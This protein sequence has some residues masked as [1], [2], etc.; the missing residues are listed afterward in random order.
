MSE[1]VVKSIEKKVKEHNEKVKE[2]GLAEWRKINVGQAKAVVRRGL[3]AYSTSHRPSVT[4]RTQWGLARLNAFI[5]LMLKDKPKNPKYVTDNDLLPKKHPR[6]SAEKKSLDIFETVVKML[7]MTEPD[8]DVYEKTLDI[9]DY[10]EVEADKLITFNKISYKLNAEPNTVEYD[11]L[12]HTI[13]NLRLEFSNNPDEI[14][15]EKIMKTMNVLPEDGEYIQ[16]V[17]ARTGASATNLRSQ[18]QLIDQAVERW[19]TNAR[20]QEYLKNRSNPTQSVYYNIKIPKSRE[21]DKGKEVSSREAVS[22]ERQGGAARRGTKRKIR[23]SLANLNNNRFVKN[24]LKNINEI[25]EEENEKVKNEKDKKP[26]LKNWM[27][28][29]RNSSLYASLLKQGKITKRQDRLLKKAQNEVK[30]SRAGKQAVRSV[31][32]QFAS[33]FSIMVFCPFHF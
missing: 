24:A 8:K 22:A 16:K 32:D 3:G 12:V 27:Q 21:R 4:S 20:L 23:V 29:D 19:G 6:H 2:E 5:H 15:F 10:D 7:D 1:D 31:L 28:I 18:A 9:L 11:E 33:N 30:K 25:I 14:V 17:L 13:D 26:L